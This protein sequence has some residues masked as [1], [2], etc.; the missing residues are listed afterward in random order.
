MGSGWKSENSASSLNLERTVSHLLEDLRNSGVD[1]SPAWKMDGINGSCSYF[2]LELNTM[3]GGGK[4]LF[5]V[6]K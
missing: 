2:T 6:T 3:F 1:F 5:L 4:Q